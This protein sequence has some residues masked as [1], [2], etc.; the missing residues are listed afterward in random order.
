M[1]SWGI[2]EN[3]DPQWV[4]QLQYRRERHKMMLLT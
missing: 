4:K 1:F 2:K 3:I